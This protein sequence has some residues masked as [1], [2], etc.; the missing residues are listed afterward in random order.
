MKVLIVEDEILIREIL[1]INLLEEEFIVYESGEGIEAIDI[2]KEKQPDVIILDINLPDISGLDICK[3]IKKNKKKFGNPYIMIIS[4]LNDNETVMKSFRNGADDYIR[5][6]FI[7]EE[8]IF[9][10]KK[11]FNLNISES[12]NNS[13][14]GKLLIDNKERINY[15]EIPYELTNKEYELSK[16]FRENS[17]KIC[18]REM[19][20]EKVW[21]KKYKFGDRR[22]DTFV[23]KI[24][25]K[26]PLMKKGLKT[27]I[28]RGYKFEIDN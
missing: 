17:N 4:A 27:L 14:Y 7:S 8:I 24:R 1:K 28:G 13:G 18:T 22:V 12:S 15:E 11:V 19:I 26:D 2:A 21:N 3:F 6:P 16:F 25:D 23:R 10:L 5:K 9:K 20:M